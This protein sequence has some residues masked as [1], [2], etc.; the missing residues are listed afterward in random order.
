V[1]AEA[2]KAA[3][4]EL[5]KHRGVF[6]STLTHGHIC[7]LP[8]VVVSGAVVYLS[9]CL[10]DTLTHT[11]TRNNNNNIINTPNVCLCV[12]VSRTCSHSPIHTP[13]NDV[14]KGSQ[15]THASFV[16]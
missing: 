1:H 3:P 5:Y 10:P 14:K 6:L 11:H 4:K 16:R 2:N 13:A 12:L 7:R 15:R 9:L 8:L